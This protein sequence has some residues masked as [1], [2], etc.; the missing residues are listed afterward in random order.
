MKFIKKSLNKQRILKN[1]E[2]N[3]RLRTSCAPAVGRGNFKKLE[4]ED[5]AVQSI[6]ANMRFRLRLHPNCLWS[7]TPDGNF[8]YSRNVVINKFAPM[9]L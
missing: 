7:Q 8:S 9:D 3:N 4:F 5:G 1:S 2:R 6:T